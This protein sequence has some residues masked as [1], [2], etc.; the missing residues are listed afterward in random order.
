MENYVSWSDLIGLLTF[1]VAGI[2]LVF[3]I[4]QYVDN[5]KK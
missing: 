2:T 1:V 3:T 5:K 4:L